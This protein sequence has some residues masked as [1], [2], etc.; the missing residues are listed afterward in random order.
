[1][2][3]PYCLNRGGGDCHELEVLLTVFI[4]K[5]SLK[6]LLN[7]FWVRL[8]HCVINRQYSILLFK[9]R[10]K[11]FLV[12]FK[13]VKIDFYFY[14]YYYYFTYGKAALLMS[15]RAKSKLELSR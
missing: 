7:C 12:I 13:L 2:I 10:C 3:F 15:L 5:Y 11:I 1:M 8:Y 6:S 9:K 14:H 4:Q